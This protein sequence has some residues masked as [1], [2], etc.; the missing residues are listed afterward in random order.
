MKKILLC[1]SML[2]ILQSCF[3]SSESTLTGLSLQESEEFSIQIP[4][5][6]GAVSQADIPT[7]KSGEVALAYSS[8]SERQGYL[9]NIVVLSTPSKSSETSDSLMKNSIQSLQNDIENFKIIEE[10]TVSFLDSSNGI[11]V[12]Y[13]GKYNTTTPQATYIQTAR[14]CGDNNYYL[15][16][17]LTENLENYDRYEY[18]LQT[19]TCN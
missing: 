9:N 6:W 12:S 10:K 14:I 16:L 3:W 2:V 17:S 8:N 18:I 11:I 5:S 7:P 13:S 4:E 1:L 15:T 19:F